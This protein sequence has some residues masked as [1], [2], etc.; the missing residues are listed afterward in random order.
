MYMLNNVY[1]LLAV[2]LIGPAGLSRRGSMQ[3]Q[4]SDSIVGSP[5]KPHLR[6]CSR[7]EAEFE[8]LESLGSG[9]FGDVVKVG[10]AHSGVCYMRQN[11]FGLAVLLAF[12]V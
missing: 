11:P 12:N 9:G 3:F 4:R 10:R 7:L 5:A 2:F 6:G 1:P 8:E